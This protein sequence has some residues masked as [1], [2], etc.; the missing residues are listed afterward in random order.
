MGVVGIPAPMGVSLILAFG[1][2]LMSGLFALTLVM[3]IENM[4]LIWLSQALFFASASFIFWSGICERFPFGSATI[5]AVTAGVAYYTKK[6]SMPIPAAVILN[7]VSLSVTITNWMFGLLM[8]LQFFNIKK[9]IK[10]TIYA[11]LITVLLWSME[12]LFIEQRNSLLHIESWNQKFVLNSYA[13]PFY[14]K[15]VALLGHTIVIPTIHLYGFAEGIGAEAQEMLGVSH[16]MPGSG[17]LLA[18]L[19]AI[20]WSFIF[21][22]GGFLW[23]RKKGKTTFDRFLFFAI[24]GQI[25]LHMFYGVELF[26]YGLHVV[27]LVLLLLVRGFNE[28]TGTMRRSLVMAL[29]LFVPLLAFHNINQYIE[30]RALYLERYEKRLYSS[31]QNTPLENIRKQTLPDSGLD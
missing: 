11:L 7:I 25:T 6:K 18:N 21:V 5:L 14:Q 22:I 2:G 17:S 24:L 4:L 9:S 1:V 19:L 27:P 26:L 10:V 12:Q 13:G 28:T 30:A 8:T 29:C 31:T 3:T 15:L 16:S 23:W 20:T